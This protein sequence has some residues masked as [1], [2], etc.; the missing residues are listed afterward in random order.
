MIQELAFR[1]I[2]N[3][4]SSTYTAFFMMYIR[5]QTVSMT[6]PIIRMQIKKSLIWGTSIR[7]G[8]I[9]LSPFNPEVYPLSYPAMNRL[10]RRAML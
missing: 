5:H 8:K 9:Y 10:Q 1:Q 7:D 3:S 4:E 2:S 6:Y